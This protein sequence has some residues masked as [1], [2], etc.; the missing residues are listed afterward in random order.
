[1]T[2]KPDKISP[3]KKK[4]KSIPAGMDDKPL[5][6]VN[7]KV[8]E[9]CDQDAKNRILPTIGNLER[10]LDFYGIQCRYNSISKQLEITVPSINLSQDNKLP[11][12]FALIHSKMEECEMPTKNYKEYLGY[13]G[14]MNWFNPVL[15]W[16]ESKPWDGI[17][18]IN[19]LCKTIEAVNEDAKNIFIERWLYQT[20]AL[21]TMDNVDG[22]G[23]LVLQSPQRMGKTWWFRKLVPEPLGSE[24]IKTGARINP[25]DRDSVSQAIRY[26][27]VELGEIDATFKKTD[28]SALKA[29]LTN[30]SDILRRP[31]GTG[32]QVY[33]RRTAFAGSVNPGIYLN[34][35]TGNRRFWTVPCTNIDSYH[36]I[37]MQQ[38]W[39]EIHYN[40][41]AGARW[42]MN[43]EE[44]DIV[45]KINLEHEQIDPLEEMILLKYN[46]GSFVRDQKTATQIAEEIG[47]KNINYATTRSITQI[48]KKLG[49]QATRKTS[50]R[51]FDIPPKV[52]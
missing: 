4:S 49:S 11:A 28:I 45:D 26:W 32:D 33:P 50:G 22:T 14:E 29:F 42:R 3:I 7:Q 41:K 23:I 10:L 21:V 52:I 19:D 2:T 25:A 27:I 48:M 1:M 9:F 31:Y 47:I 18:R 38:L 17:S 6:T 46:W 5:M 12:S 16:I 43:N 36:K 44:Y 51:Y 24:V 39:A 30:P 15:E 20:V 34:D 35:E 8:L 40:L 13:I 37:D